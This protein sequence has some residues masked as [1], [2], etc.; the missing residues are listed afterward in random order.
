[1]FGQF[2]RQKE[3]DS[4]LNLARCDGQ[5]F[6]VVSQARGFSRN[7]FEDV[8]DEAI[9][10]AHCLRRYSSI[11]VNLLQNFEYVNSVRFLALR[12]TL[13]LTIILRDVLL[14]LVGLL[15]CLSFFG[16][17]ILFCFL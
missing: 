17:A 16:A 2:T 12:T 3:T 14:C 7:P 9:H 1:M 5:A 10:D 15:C 6:V 8:V 4:C 13:L 11:G